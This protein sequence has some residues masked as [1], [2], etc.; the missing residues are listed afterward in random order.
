MHI[1]MEILSIMTPGTDSGSSVRPELKS[2]NDASDS[3]FFKTL[4]QEF[5]KFNSRTG[6]AKVNTPENEDETLVAGVMG[7]LQIEIV[8][9]LE[10]YSQTAFSADMIVEN[11]IESQMDLVANE[12]IELAQGKF[13]GEVQPQ[14]TISQFITGT[15]D[16]A[17][18]VAE[19]TKMT[20]PEPETAS[21]E[22]VATVDGEAM[23]RMPELRTQDSQEKGEENSGFSENGNLSPL[24]NMNDGAKRV[25]QSEKTYSQAEEAVKTTMNNTEVTISEVQLPLYEG[26]KA[27]QFQATQQMTQASL[28]TP[29]SAEN[30]F[31]EMISRVEMMQNDAKST[32]TIQLNP[33]WLGKVALEVSVDAAGLH[34]KINADDGAVR[35]MING[36]LSTLIESL[37]SKGIEVVGVEV[38]YTGVDNGAFKEQGESGQRHTGRHKLSNSETNSTDGDAYYT[39]LPDLLD[40]YFE[41]GVSSVEYEA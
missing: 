3:S 38:A 4:K 6:I 17:K 36:Q 11:A 1:P 23:A 14:T 40:Y 9:I 12:E 5:A 27:E 34:V 32:M 20:M 21:M 22:N 30:L 8:H 26:I 18:M 25:G 33:E 37:E 10:G 35:S 41:A 13:S 31:H 19:M 2:G 16:Y 15:S 29:V 39:S 28:N 24:E 7:T